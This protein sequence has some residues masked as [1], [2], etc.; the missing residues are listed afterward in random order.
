[1]NIAKRM[2]L[3]AKVKY[4]SWKAED[5]LDAWRNADEQLK[6]AIKELKDFN[7]EA[8]KETEEMYN[9]F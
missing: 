4:A 5:A 8:M 3:E 1:M 6:E 2:Y 9:Y 7:E